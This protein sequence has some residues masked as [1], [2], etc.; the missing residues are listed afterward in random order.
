M[1]KT[2]QC[3]ICKEIKPLSQ[4]SF[5]VNIGRYNCYCKPCCSEK[6]KQWKR[7]NPNYFKERVKNDPEYY[8]KYRQKYGQAKKSRSL[9]RKY[10]ISI[11]GYNDLFDLQEGKCAVCGTHQSVLSGK[12]VI[13]HDHTT[14]KL[15]GLL[16]TTCNTAIGMLKD[17]P[18]LAISL[19][20]YLINAQDKKVQE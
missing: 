17:N 1:E 14:G 4:F 20:N 2:K 7:D 13:D 15:R 16:C 6:A 9:L 18:Q 10:G 5:K 11:R 8:R 19:A 3:S 12:L